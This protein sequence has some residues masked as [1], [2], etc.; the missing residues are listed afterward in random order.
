MAQ[1]RAIWLQHE[2]CP[3]KLLIVL[4]MSTVDLK[5]CGGDWSRVNFQNIKWASTLREQRQVHCEH[6]EWQSQCHIPKF[7]SSPSKAST[8]RQALWMVIHPTYEGMY[9]LRAF[10]FS[11]IILRSRD[12]HAKQ[13]HWVQIKSYFKSSS[14]VGEGKSHTQGTVEVRSANGNV[15]PVI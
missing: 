6:I 1:L 4:L 11:N 14:I 13:V 12:G 7:L 10:F 3:F 2:S 5:I 15:E 9:K 8:S